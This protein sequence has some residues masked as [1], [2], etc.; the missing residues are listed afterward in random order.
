MSRFVDIA[1][2]VPVALEPADHGEF[3]G[4]EPVL[5]FHGTSGERAVVTELLGIRVLGSRAVGVVPAVGVIG[6]PG[7]VRGLEQQV[8]AAVVIAHHEDDVARASVVGSRGPCDV[9]AGCRV[10]RHAPG[11]RNAP[12]AAV[13]QVVVGRP[14]DERA[15]RLL[16]LGGARRVDR[17]DLPGPVALVVAEPVDVD[18]VIG[19][20]RVDLELDRL[21][22]VHADLR[23]V[24]LDALVAGAVDIP[25]RSGRPGQAV[26]RGDLVVRGLRGLGG[27]QHDGHRQQHQCCCD[28]CD[29]GL[30]GG[31][32]AVGRAAT[33]EG[34]I[35]S[36]TLGSGGGVAQSR[37][38]AAT[39]MPPE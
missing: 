15:I 20:V 24:P 8:R 19:R 7:R 32:T 23:R 6:L 29:D 1:D 17:G 21:A 5:R 9:D 26:L 34:E 33:H 31:S 18:A 27:Q 28:G 10:G 4:E 12:V 25:F 37:D 35:G 11:R 39:P 13:D 14:V 30:R 16:G 36:R 22:L 3:G 2:V 38:P